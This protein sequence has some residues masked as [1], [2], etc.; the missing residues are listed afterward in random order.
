MLE[1][2]AVVANPVTPPVP[3]LHQAPA[4]RQ[5]SAPVADQRL[6]LDAPIHE[7]GAPVACGPRSKASPAEAQR[8]SARSKGA[9]DG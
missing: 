5:D 2:A 9:S 3:G 8:K 6:L 1:A 4:I 7:L